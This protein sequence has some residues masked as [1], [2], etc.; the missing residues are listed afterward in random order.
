[1][2]AP[3]GTEAGPRQARDALDK[4]LDD[5]SVRKRMLDLDYDIPDKAKRGPQPLAALVRADARWT[6]IIK[7]ANVKGE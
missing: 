6:P 2:F 1:M 4:T 3:K 5:P 7:A